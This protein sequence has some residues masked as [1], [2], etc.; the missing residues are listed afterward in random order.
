MKIKMPS[1]ELIHIAFEQGEAA[2]V[3]L[4]MQLGLEVQQLATQLVEQAAAIQ[5]LKGRLDKDSHNSSKPPSSDGYG[6]KNSDEK[7]TESLRKSGQKPNGGQEGHQG[8]TLKKSEHPHHVE[9]SK[10]TSCLH[11]GTSLDD[12][13]ASDYEERQVFDIPAI[14]I[15]IS[16]FKAEIKICPQCQCENRG[17]FPD[18]VCQP[19]QYGNGVKTWASYFPNQHYV[20]V[21][22]TAKIFE[23]L[24]NHRVSEATILKASESLDHHIS[25]STEAVKGLLQHSDVTH[26]DESGLR[27]K[28]KLHWLHVAS[29]KLF[30]YYQVHAKRGTEAMDDAGVLPEFSGTAVHDH[31]KSYFKYDMCKHALC[32]AHHLREFQFIEK[33]YEQ[34]WAKD[35]ALLLLQIDKAVTDARIVTLTSLPIEQQT[36]FERD[37][38]RIVLEGYNVNPLPQLDE[39]H[40]KPKKRGRKKHTPP[41]NLLN[42]LRDYKAE[43]LAFM[44]DFRVPF[45]NNLAE[46]DVRMIKVKQKVSGCFRTFEGAEHFVNIRGYIST[47][48]KNKLNAY[49]AIKNAFSGHPFIPSL[50]IP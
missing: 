3:E 40:E 31:W 44:Y 23:D 6:K 47:A 7:R 43:T 41:Q 22:R 15:E 39:N 37:Y 27:V 13:K 25:P 49:D 45:T 38:D 18:D 10:V 12:E 28:G 24:L 5:E 19:T 33:Q 17:E 32:N 46:Q 36:S 34:E 20:S 30:T 35:M 9:V 4:F 21:E 1:Q 14:H 11:C 16:S 42:R 50:P 26:F 2:V 8:N 29:N 48:R